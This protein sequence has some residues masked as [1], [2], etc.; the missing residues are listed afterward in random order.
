MSE[1]IDALTAVV[2]KLEQR[3]RLLEDEQAILQTMY[4]YGHALDYGAEDEFRDCWDENAVLYW[5]DREPARGHDAIV[6]QFRSHTHAPG[7]YHKHLVIAPRIRIEGD[8][9]TATSYFVRLDRYPDGPHVRNFGRYHDVFTRCA[10]GR[11]RFLER[12]AENEARRGQPSEA[13]EFQR[14]STGT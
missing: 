6:S 2:A 14:T 10:D 13:D 11:W 7:A 3:L 4:A 1:S 5:T 12:R 8:R 9:A